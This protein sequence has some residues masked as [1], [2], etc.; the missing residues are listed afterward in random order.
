MTSCDVIQIALAQ[1]A[2]QEVN[3]SDYQLI[4]KSPDRGTYSYNNIHIVQYIIM[5]T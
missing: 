3:F 2:P 5:Y 1:I 4:E